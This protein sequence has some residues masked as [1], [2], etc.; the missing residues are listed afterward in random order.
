[1]LLT[2]LGKTQA[3]ELRKEFARRFLEGPLDFSMKALQSLGWIAV[4]AGNNISERH[5]S[6][7]AAAAREAGIHEGLAVTTEPGIYVEAVRV[8]LTEDGILA[9][10][11]NCMLRA[12]LLVAQD[13]SFA[14]LDEGDYYFLIA[15]LPE[16][17][18]RAV[19]GD[20]AEAQNEFFRYAS[21]SQWP[22]KTRDFLLEIHYRYSV[23]A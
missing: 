11:A 1:M 6:A 21:R 15:G 12:F 22:L 18:E 9:F 16:F 5:A 10:D 23:P 13:E 3:E 4:P 17:V 20:I 8:K 19:G 7:I 14:I 2:R